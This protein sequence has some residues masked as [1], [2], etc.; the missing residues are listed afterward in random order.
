MNYFSFKLLILDCDISVLS[1]ASFISNFQ[2]CYK[3]GKP[4]Q[5][6]IN[7]HAPLCIINSQT[8]SNF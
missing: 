7:F 4:N 2:L 1:F 3:H 8:L 5:Y 6:G